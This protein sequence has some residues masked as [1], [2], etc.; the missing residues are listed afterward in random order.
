MWRILPDNKNTKSHALRTVHQNGNGILIVLIWQDRNITHHRG[1]EIHLESE[2][3]G[4]IK[5][6]EKL[7]VLAVTRSRKLVSRTEQLA[8]GEQLRIETPRG[9]RRKERTRST[10]AW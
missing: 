5:A 4:N 2:T 1:Q 8:I 3:K 10:K 7:T 9:M 6:E